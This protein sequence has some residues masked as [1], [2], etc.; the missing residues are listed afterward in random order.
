[1]KEIWKDIK[2][3]EGLYQ[4]SNLG[5]VKALYR[6]WI[7][8]RGAKRKHEEFILKPFNFKGYS[9]VSLTK[10]GKIKDYLIHRLV[11]Q[12][13]VGHSSLECNHIDGKKSNNYINN[14]E[15]CTRSQN[16]R[17]AINNHLYKTKLTLSQVYRIKFIDKYC[18][19][20]WGYWTKLSR[21]LNISQ[22]TVCDIIKNRTWKHVIL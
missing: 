10:N 13:F 18:N 19:P 22:P 9:R 17:H 11:L 1:M 6:E 12:A 14:L 21:S 2:G 20:K 16:V 7:S 3:Y 5:D 4:V 8:G 15:Y